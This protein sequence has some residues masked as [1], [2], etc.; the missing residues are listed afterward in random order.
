MDAG[1]ET[2]DETHGNAAQEGMGT[3]AAAATWTTH[4]QGQE[5]GIQHDLKD[6]QGIGVPKMAGT[7]CV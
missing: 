2:Q 5:N 4:P 3:C 6:G 1:E 7:E